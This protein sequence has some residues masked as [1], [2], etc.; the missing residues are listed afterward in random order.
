MEI[1]KRTTEVEKET[2]SSTGYGER[3]QVSYN[4]YGHLVLRFFNKDPLP[5]LSASTCTICGTPVQRYGKQTWMH[6]KSMIST[7]DTLITVPQEHTA[8]PKD[9]PP[10][11]PQE[12]LIVLDQDESATLIR[13]VQEHVK[14]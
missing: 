1:I 9:E 3:I 13:F 4:S 6:V 5:V 10:I 11:P 8:I 7:S 2:V 14:A 12:T